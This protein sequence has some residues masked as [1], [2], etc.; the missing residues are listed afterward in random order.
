MSIGY[1]EKKMFDQQHA[2]NGSE[3]KRSIDGGDIKCLPMLFMK[4]RDLSSA[5]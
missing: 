2:R 4:T 1:F 5:G 3:K